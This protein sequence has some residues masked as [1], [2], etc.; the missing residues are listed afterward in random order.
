MHIV[1]IRNSSMHIRISAIFNIRN[2]LVALD[3]AMNSCT[4]FC[5][6]M[7]HKHSFF[8]LIRKKDLSL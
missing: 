1:H 7:A 2:L 8:L 4:V 6:L 5:I 3:L